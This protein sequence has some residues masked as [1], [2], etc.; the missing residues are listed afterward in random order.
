MKIF[1]SG[2]SW[3]LLSVTAGL[4][5]FGGGQFSVAET[6]PKPLADLEAYLA[7]PREQRAELADQAFAN[8]PLNR[9]EAIAASQLLWQEH[10]AWIRQTRQAEIQA[11]RI[12]LDNKQMPF[13]VKKF[14][15]KPATGYSLVLSMH[16]GGQAPAP[17]NDRQ[18]QN[19]QSLYTLTEGVYVAPRAPTNNWNL[20]HEAHIDAMFDRLIEDLVVFE[21][22]NPNRVYLTGYSAGG[23]GVYQLAPRMADRFAAAAMMAGHPNEASPLGLRNLPFAIHMGEKDSAYKRN[24]VAQ[25]WGKSLEKLHQADPEGYVFQV[26][27][28]EGMGHWMNRQD[29]EALPW[30]AQFTRNP[31]PKKIVW[32]QDDVLQRRFYWLS[33]DTSQVK[34]GTEITAQVTGQTVD[35]Q[36]PAGLP[37]TVRL[38][39]DLV[40]LNQPVQIITNGKSTTPRELKRTI[41]VLARSLAERGDPTATF[42]SELTVEL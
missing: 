23:D 36:G 6:L 20:W 28:H 34:A 16:G 32:R 37:L 41:R 11:G 24:E 18:W 10:R 25:T 19:Q 29:A 8:Q 26:K 1:G 2:S 30:M 7:Q 17:V 5:W 38:R 33:V 14:G 27:L 21:E 39:D 3:L 15:E 22:V 35:L 31:S 4:A 12:E 9:E 13:V 40:D 42:A